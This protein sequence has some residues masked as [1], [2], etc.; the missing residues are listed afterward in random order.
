MLQTELEKEPEKNM[1]VHKVQTE[2][3]KQPIKNKNA[4]H[5]FNMVDISEIQPG[6]EFLTTTGKHF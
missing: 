4:I 2:L 5:I 6:E 1:C 3:D